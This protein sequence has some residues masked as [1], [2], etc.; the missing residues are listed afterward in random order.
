MSGSVGI[1]GAGLEGAAAARWF[2]GRPLT[3][4]TDNP[5]DPLPG[6]D[7]LWGADA[8]AALGGIELLVRSPG[9]A[10]HHPLR[11]R[12]DALG[13][14]QTTTTRLFLAE[15][16]RRGIRVL[17]VTGSKGKSTTTTLAAAFLN[18]AGHSAHALG[19]VG[20]PALDALDELVGGIAV[21]EVSSYQAADLETGPDRAILTS[22]FPEHLDWHGGFEPYLAAKLNLLERT[23]G[24]V[25]VPAGF[26]H[27]ATA[28]TFGAP[29]QAHMRDGHFVGA[30]GATVP[31]RAFRL[32]G[33][34]MAHNVLSAW[35]AT[36]DWGVSAAEVEGV[37]EAFA[38]L[39][40]RLEDL[41]I[42]DGR[43]W[44][45][46]AISTAPEATAAA[47]EAWP[48]TSTLIVGGKDRGY[49]VDPAVRAIAASTELRCVIGLPETGPRVLAGV[50]ANVAKLQFDDLAEA[51]THARAVTPAGGTV[52]F[53]PGGPS[54]HRWRDFS[55][56]GAAFRAAVYGR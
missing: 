18:A 24:P 20:R 45:N 49:D 34:A 40:H 22:L 31:R 50:S 2:R 3:V 17:A 47:L 37:L 48:E 26:K 6:A 23:Q 56:R 15:T 13:I 28:H 53:S 43:R 41:G 29:P 44:V 19:N 7:C 12:A 36:A 30:D 46:D 52:L 16:A 33:D 9:F 25:W 27:L 55:E 38:G 4:L 10:P 1:L 14:P 54:Y 51:V 8:A 5:A 21:L 32:R 39:P 11:R 42:V 35:S